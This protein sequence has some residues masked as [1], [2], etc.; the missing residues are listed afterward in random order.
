[1]SD[2]AGGVIM[3]S[4]M[5][6]AWLG[7]VK[8]ASGKALLVSLGLAIKKGQYW[9]NNI[10]FYTTLKLNSCVKTRINNLINLIHYI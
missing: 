10:I 9:S 6:V 4:Q 3:E 1:M 7:S 8:G 5:N 2:K